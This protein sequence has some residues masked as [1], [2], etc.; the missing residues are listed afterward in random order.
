M[1]KITLLF[2]F[3]FCSLVFLGAQENVFIQE[4]SNKKDVPAIVLKKYALPSIEEFYWQSVGADKSNPT[5]QLRLIGTKSETF[6]TFLSQW[7][8]GDSSMLQYNSMFG[9]KSLDR[10]LLY[11]PMASSWD[12]NFQYVY[13]YNLNG[14]LKSTQVEDWNVSTW[15]PT[16]KTT[17]LYDMQGNVVEEYD[18]IYITSSWFPSSKIVYYINPLNQVEI[19][20]N[21]VWN[22]TTLSWDVISRMLYGYNEFGQEISNVYQNWNGSAWV[23]NTKNIAYYTPSNKYIGGRYYSW[24]NGTSSWKLDAR[25]TV[26]IQSATAQEVYFYIDNGGGTLEPSTKFIEV[27]FT[28]GLLNTR[29]EQHWDAGTST[30][31]NYSKNE[32]TVNVNDNYATLTIQ[33]W[34]NI[35]SQFKNY[36]LTEYTY[37]SDFYLTFTL[38]KNWDN[39]TNSWVNNYRQYKW[40]EPDPFFGVSAPAFNFAL[41]VYPNPCSEGIW[42]NIETWDDTAGEGIIY[43]YDISGKK[44][45]E[46]QLNFETNQ[47]VYLPL[48]ALHAGAYVIIMQAGNQ[49]Y[50]QIIIK[51]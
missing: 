12:N 17:Y 6:N 50:K 44:V 23:N 4:V 43:L 30:F 28:N 49:S 32:Y 31:I 10:Q 24:D 51:Q 15:E 36:S 37:N 25:D 29:I 40:Y 22:N 45:S 13:A 2:S 8:G 19:R 33:F 1:K 3:I 27:Y 41:S 7:M 5:G 11:D 38:R 48:H 46:Y 26:I 39:S 21:H 20:T 14:T 47:S 18:S 16:N 34:D 42:V 9:K 35:T